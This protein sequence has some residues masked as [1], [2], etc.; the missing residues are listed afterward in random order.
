MCL[1]GYLFKNKLTGPHEK[2]GKALLEIGRLLQ[3]ATRRWAYQ[4]GEL[5]EKSDCTVLPQEG[6][7]MSFK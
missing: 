6:N 3:N 4:K 2:N 7:H 1:S 5:I